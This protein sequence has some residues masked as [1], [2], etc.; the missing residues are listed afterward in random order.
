MNLGLLRTGNLAYLQDR[1][2]AG[3]FNRSLKRLRTIMINSHMDEHARLIQRSVPYTNLVLV[4]GHMRQQLAMTNGHLTKQNLMRMR[5]RI[6][7]ILRTVLRHCNRQ[8]LNILKSLNAPRK[9]RRI[10][11]IRYVNY[12]MSLNFMDNF[13]VNI[14]NRINL[15]L[16]HFIRILS[17][18]HR[19]LHGPTIQYMNRFINIQRNNN[20]HTNSRHS[21]VV[22]GLGNSA[23][24]VM[25]R[26]NRLVKN[27]RNIT[28][29]VRNMSLQDIM[30]T[31]I[32]PCSQRVLPIMTRII[33]NRIIPAKGL[34]QV[35]FG[36][37]IF[38]QGRAYRIFR[39]HPINN[40]GLNIIGPK[41]MNSLSAILTNINIL[42]QGHTSYKVVVRVPRFI[43]IQVLIITSLVVQRHRPV[44]RFLR[45]FIHSVS[46]IYDVVVASSHEVSLRRQDY[47]SGK[48]VI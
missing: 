43:L 26:I 18:L 36:L 13:R 6:I 30:N 48:R 10:L 45:Q 29:R 47:V 14:L 40:T 33:S 23:N 11:T 28:I 19:S 7:S 1:N 21:K 32:I 5:A 9:F 44:R 46:I 22:N 39:G 3:N 20:N 2:N 25:S 38:A 34:S 4:F 16:K 37:I 8:V 12:Q 27:R 35:R 31:I 17:K 42:L 41:A 24:Q 15:T